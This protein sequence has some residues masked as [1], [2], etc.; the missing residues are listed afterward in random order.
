[1]TKIFC[2]IADLK[3][4]KLYKNKVAQSIIDN[5]HKKPMGNLIVNIKYAE[6][7]RQKNKIIK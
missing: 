2:D 6:D 5:L 4:I 3:L 1:M 7:K